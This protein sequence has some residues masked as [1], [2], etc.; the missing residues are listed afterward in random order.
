MSCF[1]LLDYGLHNKYSIYVLLVLVS[2]YFLQNYARFVFSVAKIPFIDYS[3]VEYG[4]LAGPLF[5]IAYTITGLVLGRWIQKKRTTTL[6]CFVGV[7][8][9][10]VALCA[11]TTSFLQLALLT[12]CIGAAM[13]GYVPVGTSLLSDAFP[14]RLR[15]AALGLFN[16]GLFAGYGFAL[17]AGEVLYEAYAWK[18]SYL[19]PGFLLTALSLVLLETLHEPRA[20]RRN[21]IELRKEITTDGIGGGATVATRVAPAV[22]GLRETLQYWRQVPGLWLLSLAGGVRNAG[23]YCWAYY[24]ASFYSSLLEAAP[25]AGWCRYSYS[26]AGDGAT[27]EACSSSYPYCVDDMCYRISD[28]PWHNIGMDSVKYESWITWV[29]IVG[30]TCG[31][32]MGGLVSDKFATT[33]GTAARLGAA[34]ALTF[35]AVPCCALALWGPYPACFLALL[36]AYL[37]SECWLG[38]L[39]TAVAELAPPSL[40]VTSVALYMFVVA[41]IGGNA[42]MLVPVAMNFFASDVAFTVEAASGYGEDYDK[43][44]EYTE[45][46]WTS[47]LESAMMLLWPGFYFLSVGLLMLAREQISRDLRESDEIA[48]GEALYG[49]WCGPEEGEERRGLLAASEGVGGAAVP[50]AR[51]HGNGGNAGYA[52]T[53]ASLKEGRSV[54]L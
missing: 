28:T 42:A 43:A 32:T 14:L 52:A 15:G 1:E 27:S 48:G 40:S 51:R 53:A 26:E 21:S 38:I 19:A 17:G 5:N 33:G 4:L 39:L 11:I 22:G 10:L 3:S 36:M 9:A 13:A 44:T 30:G 31:S 37:L 20:Q 23:G 34:A 29:I 45:V 54:M 2:G 24:A 6:A 12:I 35:A 7:S 46:R 47:G 41:N 18:W 49:A 8:G 25:S 16:V 50:L